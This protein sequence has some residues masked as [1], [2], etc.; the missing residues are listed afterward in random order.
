MDIGVAV[1]LGFRK[2][3]WYGILITLG[4]LLAVQVGSREF[5][6]RG[7]DPA[8]V[9]DGSLWVIGL[10]ILGARLY[11]VFSTPNDGSYS[12]WN[13]YSQ[14]PLKILAV[15][16]GGLGIWGGII[17]GIAGIGYVMWRNRIKLFRAFDAIVPGVLLGQAIGRWGNFTNQELYGP[18]TGSDWFGLLIDPSKRIRTGKF[19]FSDLTQFPVDTRFQPTFLYESMWNLI[20]FGLLMWLASRKQENPITTEQLHVASE[21]DA[22]A[23]IPLSLLGTYQPAGKPL[24]RD[25]DIGPLFLLW[26]GIGRSWV[27]LLFRPDAWTLGSLPTAVWVALAMI[28]A[29]I[30]MLLLNRLPRK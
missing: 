29:A 5:K 22:P 16:E 30:V 9:S 2:I 19:D 24:L 13:Y 8:I 23:P 18:P 3:Y 4:M 17:G 7:M 12:G 1:D 20:G 25:G 11:H 10:G 28:V 15:W 26:Y 21:G 6:R 14:N 27:E